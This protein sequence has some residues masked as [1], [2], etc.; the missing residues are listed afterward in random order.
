[1]P[2]VPIDVVPA[3]VVPVPVPVVP[4]PLV[5]VPVVPGPVVPVP[6]V[7]VPTST[8]AGSLP[9]PGA[10]TDSVPRF[11]AT[12]T[13]LPVRP[14][15]SGATLALTGVDVGLL[16]LLALAAVSGGALMT[17]LAQRPAP[18]EPLA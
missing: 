9:S 12:A 7:P 2:V 16:M 3:P 15:V 13:I 4:V 18:R 5:P 17:L 10:V 1:V 14:Q 11:A 8:P 6:V